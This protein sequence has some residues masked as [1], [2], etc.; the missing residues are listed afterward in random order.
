[1]PVSMS[2]LTDYG[3]MMNRSQYIYKPISQSQIGNPVKCMKIP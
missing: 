1:M 2:L 3:R